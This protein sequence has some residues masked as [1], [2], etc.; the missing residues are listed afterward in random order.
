MKNAL[1]ISY[2][3]LS[4]LLLAVLLVS[5]GYRFMEALFI[6]SLFLPGG[7]AV[8]YMFPK[9]HN[10]VQAVYM[11]LGIMVIEILL[12][13]VAH[14]CIALIRAGNDPSGVDLPS[15]LC[16]P[17]FIALIIIVL[18]V[19]YYFYEQWLDRKFTSEEGP[20]T[21]L[22]ERKRISLMRSEIRYIE[23]NDSVTVVYATQGRSFRNKTPISQ[24]E[25]YLGKGFLR[26][27]RSYLVNVDYIRDHNADF[28]FL[29]D[30]DLPVSRKYRD[31]VN[32][33]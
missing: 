6:A 11:T 12:F 27:H 16:N 5:I 28:V 32:S 4:V 20:V 21:F 29:E 1:V 19:G 2:W 23:S 24:W 3:I 9:T 26:I 15:I 8:R 18:A 25:D 17:V 33:L 14:R 13:V 7:M 30:T 22:S 10:A 31:S